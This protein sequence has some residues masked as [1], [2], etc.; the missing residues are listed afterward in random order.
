MAGP[1]KKKK[2]KK[3]INNYQDTGL[4]ISLLIKN[5]AQLDF[6]G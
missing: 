6:F 1:H 5:I 2:K 3:V 4:N